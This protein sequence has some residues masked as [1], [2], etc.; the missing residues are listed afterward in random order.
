MAAFLSFSEL[1]DAAVLEQTARLAADERRATAA[2]IAALTEIDARR[3]YLAEGYSCMFGYCT[4]RLRLSEP[5]A[6]KRIEVAR[7][8][9]V[10]PQVLD[11]LFRGALTL[12]TSV[13]LAPHLTRDN[14]DV[15]IAAASFKTK[16]EVEPL[17]A[18][19]APKPD[20]PAVVRKQP[21]PTEHPISAPALLLEQPG[22]E[23]PSAP[24]PSIPPRAVTPL[25]PA[26]YKVQF[27]A[28]QD[29]HDKLRHAQAL[30]RHQISSGDLCAIVNKALTLLIADAE[31]T[32]IG[33]VARPRAGGKDPRPGSR[34]IPAAVRRAVAARDKEQ[35]A[36]VGHAGRCPERGF[37]EFHH[38]R[39]FAAG[40]PATVENIELR[41]R[42]HNA[43]EAVVFFGEEAASHGRHP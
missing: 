33:K 9:R 26:R 3:L 19:L 8:A 7:I 39:P 5:A 41:C 1:S 12:S 22:A 35:C 27:T 2:L 42:A 21:Q 14:S 43:H 15:L 23:Q 17:I 11:A 28:D 30:L 25:A 20:V 38:V 31:R 36:F 4:I 34:H 10:F 18:A 29:T 13:L 37:L 24:R 6:Y 16:R 32:K 40:G